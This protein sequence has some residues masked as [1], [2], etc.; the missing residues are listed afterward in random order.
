MAYL[1]D[2]AAV[3]TWT[4]RRICRDIPD[5]QAQQIEDYLRSEFAEAKAEGFAEGRTAE[6]SGSDDE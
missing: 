4:I 1:K 5:Q 3:A 2:R 6:R